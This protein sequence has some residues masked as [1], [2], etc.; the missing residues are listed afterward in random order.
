MFFICLFF[1][2]VYSTLMDIA[3]LYELFRKNSTISTD[4]RSIIP[5]SIFFALPGAHFDGNKFASDALE[6]GAAYAVVSDES[7][8][9]DQFIRVE[10]PLFTLQSLANYHRKHFNIPFIA[11]TGSNGK[12]TTKE[13]ITSVLS[14]KYKVHA[15]KGNYNNHIG[16]PLTLLQMSNDVEIAVIEMGAN[17]PGEI[18]M[19]CEIAMP[20]HGLIT[21]IGKAHLEGFASIEGVQQAKGE[22]FQYLKDHNGYAFVNNDDHRLVE[23]G[24]SLI[25]KTT[26]SLNSNDGADVSLRYTPD[27]SRNGFTLIDENG[28]IEIG[29]SMFGQ[30]NA[31]NMLA[32]FTVGLHFKV[33]SSW[34]K[35]SLSNFV[36]GSNRSEVVTHAGCTVIKDAYNANPSSMELALRS[37]A[38]QYKDGWVVL[39][40]MKELGDESEIAHQDIIDVVLNLGIQRVFLVGETFNKS[41]LKRHPGETQRLFSYPTIESLKEKW[42]W[43][44]CNRKAILLKGSRSMRLEQLLQS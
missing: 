22:L 29:S 35:E 20:T 33:D 27:E 12:T 37:F 38:H 10:D 43:E 44:D 15:T 9:G 24:E 36:S 1:T 31:I 39:G 2:P 3:S 18:K 40:D 17:H 5:D 13:L 21:N 16:V 14:G 30:Y 41:Y 11:I 26:Y 34:L 7:L 4:T 42:N 19:L 32:A 6:K 25:E 23:L 8:S 28:L